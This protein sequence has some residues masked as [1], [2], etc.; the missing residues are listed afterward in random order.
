M[1]GL[2]KYFITIIIV[3][4][5]IGYFYYDSKILNNFSLLPSYNLANR[6][7]FNLN[8]NKSDTSTRSTLAPKVFSNNLININKSKINKLFD[9]LKQEESVYG[10]ILD[11]LDVPS[12]TKLS[13]DDQNYVK[14]IEA[15]YSIKIS[16]YFNLDNG[17]LGITDT[18]ERYLLE[19]SEKNLH[20]RVLP[21]NNITN[22]FFFRYH[23][24][25]FLNFVY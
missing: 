23:K 15:K 13:N 4:L 5:L 21:K 18:F 9:I 14:K 25:L 22:V 7:I 11:D 17:K 6:P 10:S 19:K 1:Q 8:L 24:K 12:F 2:Q 3:L 16:D 20:R